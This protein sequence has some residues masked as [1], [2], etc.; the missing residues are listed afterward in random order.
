MGEGKKVRHHPKESPVLD[1]PLLIS[2]CMSTGRDVRK[3]L[4]VP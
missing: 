3:T 2:E 1:V 4:S